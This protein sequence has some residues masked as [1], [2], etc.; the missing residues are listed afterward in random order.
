MICTR[1]WKGYS[2]HSMAGTEEVYSPAFFCFFLA[3]SSSSPFEAF[4]MAFGFGFGLGFGAGFSDPESISIAS[5]PS[6]PFLGFGLALAFFGLSSLPSLSP[7][8]F[9][10]FFF[11]GDFSPPSLAVPFAFA[12]AFFFGFI[13][14][15]SPDAS[16]AVA[17]PSD[18]EL[19]SVGEPAS[20]EDASKS[21]SRH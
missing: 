2:N 11:A 3:G 6:P 10:F 18:S 14:S 8:A 21:S 17:P 15:R 20:E 4:V 16:D 7:S 5:S 13:I 1:S 9:F 12:F 19:V